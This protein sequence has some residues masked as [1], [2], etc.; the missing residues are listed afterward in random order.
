MIKRLY[1]GLRNK[2]LVF[3]AHLSRYKRV[4]RFLSSVVLSCLFAFSLFLYPQVKAFR[5]EYLPGYYPD[6]IYI[7]YIPISG[8]SYFSKFVN[9]DIT[10]SYIINNNGNS[11]GYNASRSYYVD[12]GASDVTFNSVLRLCRSTPMYTNASAQFYYPSGSDGYTNMD[13]S[14][15][16]AY[17][18]SV[19]VFFL[20]RYRTGFSSSNPTGVGDWIPFKIIFSPQKAMYV[21]Y[22]LDLSTLS[23]S[24]NSVFY[25][26]SAPYTPAS[27]PA[28]SFFML[29]EIDIYQ[30]CKYSGLPNN[31]S[32]LQHSF[33]L[34]YTTS[35]PIPNTVVTNPYL[36]GNS[37]T[38]STNSDF[39][40]Q[41]SE[42]NSRANEYNDLEDG[43]TSQFDEDQ[44]A[45]NES[46]TGWTWGALTQGANYIATS[47]QN[48]YDNAGDFR[49]LWLFP[50]LLGVA[51]VFLG[52]WG[53]VARS[54][55]RHDNRHRG[56]S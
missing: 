28:N 18:S 21:S 55:R 25:L 23:S 50:L 5:A 34:Y 20:G 6:G 45:V 4:G 13:L 43:F 14:W 49:Q 3:K 26:L 33:Q 19:S 15:A 52:R 29:E 22:T 38:D 44:S 39:S 17:D 35:T 8:S 42:F 31:G 46:F 7:Y 40:N 53:S 32:Y 30:Y 24:S 56:G 1:N 54:K 9:A 36:E 48:L 51:L 47:I 10:S 16:G 37:D 11:Y 12:N 2:I 27:L 41:D